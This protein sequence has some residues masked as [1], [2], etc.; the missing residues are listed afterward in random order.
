MHG[1]VYTCRSRSFKPLTVVDAAATDHHVGV[2]LLLGRMT[3]SITDLSP[4]LLVKIVDVDLLDV[5]DILCLESVSK[6]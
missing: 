5:L 3:V 4:E 2:P 1:A 6:L